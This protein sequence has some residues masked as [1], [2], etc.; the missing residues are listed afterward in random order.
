MS[1][2]PNSHLYCQNNIYKIVLSFEDQREL[3]PEGNDDEN[4]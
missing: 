2:Y 4:K 1:N 3:E